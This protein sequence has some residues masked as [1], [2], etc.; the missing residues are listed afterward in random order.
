MNEIVL[1][2]MFY[3]MQ[4]SNMNNVIALFEC[5]ISCIFK[6]I[7]YS[8]KHLISIYLA[9][10]IRRHELFSILSENPMYLSFVLYYLLIFSLITPLLTKFIC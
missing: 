1:S 6:D 10:F 5:V 7:H 4:W 2:V 9:M 3:N 8:I